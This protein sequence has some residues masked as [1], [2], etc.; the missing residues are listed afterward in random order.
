MK[1]RLLNI[2]EFNSTRKRMSVILETPYKTPDGFN[3]IYIM[4]KGADSI[5]LPR[6]CEGAKYVE[7][8][9]GFID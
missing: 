2:L 1:Y 3:E 8:T 6:L 9:K 4:T 5:M 7:E